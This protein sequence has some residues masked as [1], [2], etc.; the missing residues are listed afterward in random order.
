M[1]KTYLFKN[2]KQ[3]TERQFEEELLPLLPEWRKQRSL[4]FKFTLGRILCAKAFLLLKEGLEKDFGITGNLTFDY[5]AHDKPIL[6]EHPDIHFNLSHCN[7]GIL[8]VIDNEN[9]VGC[10]IE[11]ID[12]RISGGLLKLCCNQQ[13]IDH[14]QNAADP[15][16][17]FI[18]LW[19]IKESVL[20]FTGEGIHDNLPDLLSP[21]LMQS[22]ELR[23]TIC[24]EDGFIYTICQK[25]ASAVSNSPSIK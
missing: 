8:C 5:I 22:I 6:R 25:R 4:E 3:I 16:M 7:K 19:T 20:K 21:T 24:A 11:V 2:P 17:E 12:R 1:Q 14:I 10:D 23:T 13:E 9:A 18:R 15:G